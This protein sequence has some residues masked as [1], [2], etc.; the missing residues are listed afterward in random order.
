M[1]RLLHVFLVPLLF[2]SA[3]LQINAQDH[4]Q[5][6]HHFSKVPDTRDI[7][8]YQVNI[9]AFSAAGNL[10]GVT[11]RLDSIKNLSINTIYLMPVYPVGT[12]A[13]SSNS[14]YCIKDFTSVGAEYG[15]LADLQ[16]LVES[17]HKK[18]MA[19]I[20]DWVVN[21]TSWDNPWITQH[22]DWYVKDANGNIQQL[23]SYTDVAALDMTNPQVQHA[24]VAD[25]RYWIFAANIDGFRCD[26]ADHP[27]VSFWKKTIADL[28]SN[29]TH[30]LI[31]L[32]EGSRTDNFTAGFDMNFGFNF[33][34]N[35]IIPIHSGSSVSKIQTVNNAEY[36][37]ANATQQVARY[38]G[39]HDTNGSGTPLELFGGQA[40]VMANFVVAA[41]MKGVPFLYNGQEVAFATRIP[42]PWNTVH[43]DWTPKPAV[44]DEFKKVLQF[45]SSSDAIRRGTLLNYSD[46]NVC[47]FTKTMSS[48]EVLVFSNLRSAISKYIIPPALAGT[49]NDAFSNAHKTLKALDTLTL[50]GYQYLTLTGKN[51]P[52]SRQI[53]VSPLNSSI[54]VG[55]TLPIS[56]DLASHNKK[57]VTWTSSNTSVA[58]V[59]DT[60]LVKGVAIGTAIITAALDNKNKATS[61]VTVTPQHN[62]T[63]HFFKPADWGTGINIYWY[64]I[65]PTGSLPNLNWPGTPMT[66]D[67][68]GW[69]S[70][71]FT[72][73]NS[74]VVIFNDG[75]KQSADLPRDKDGW[76][77]NGAWY[78]TKPVTS[79]NSFTVHF[80]KPADWATSIN[81]Y[82]YNA[83]PDGSYPSVSWPGVAMTNEGGGW[84]SYTFNNVASAVVIF[85][86][87]SK[88]SAD[89]AR[90]T[91]GWYLNGLWYDTKPVTASTTFT[92]SFYRPATWG[93]GI[94]IYWYNAVPDGSLP[95]PSWPG[96]PMTNNGDGWYTYTFSSATAATLIFN[97][98]TNQSA[99]TYRDKDG[100]YK[101]GVW[102]DNK[103]A[104]PDVTWTVNFF[105]PSAWGSNINIYYYNVL[106]TGALAS[107]SWPGVPMTT[108]GDGWYSYTFTNVASAV[109]IFNDGSSQSADLPRSTTG[110]Y[111]NGVWYDTKPSTST[112]VALSR[113][114]NISNTISIVQVYPNPAKN[115]GFNVYIPGLD[116]GEMANLTVMDARGNTTMKT[117]VPQL[118]KIGN[119]LRPGIY[120]I[121]IDTRKLHVTRKVVVQ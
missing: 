49:Y 118:S 84:Y 69:Y 16:T 120:L 9:R 59:N 30:K 76:Y 28:R 68:D 25:M 72:N 64:N 23:D 77:A 94:N 26:Y 96:V 21:Q 53:F 15:S 32:A 18:G 3:T 45:R 100:W 87:G 60:G 80:F 98:G 36:T 97:D 22:P 38:T 51:K 117:L 79:N 99:D 4:A 75:S 19:V 112:A 6:G 89:L 17:A 14:P 20:L 108:S 82:W 5:Y 91:T 121:R 115:N 13:K 40:G 101:D 110:W 61:L 7:N 62:F 52:E 102:Y 92:V 74:A 41:Y 88:Q 70:Y 65:D 47:A 35:A 31:M 93:T 24:M 11:A 8:L 81:I 66:N 109:V 104:T 113:S 55:T 27:P 58:T 90:S 105:K 50:G 37:S 63:V 46:V 85:N 107:V 34:Y 116:A 103:P 33:Y 106:P 95:S 71:N 111:Y 2:L 1:K 86:D 114:T 42:F 29:C 56:V 54:I 73:V 39:N 57:S 78:D 43:I 67:G 119:N 10:A 12:D 44:T 48:E 83:L